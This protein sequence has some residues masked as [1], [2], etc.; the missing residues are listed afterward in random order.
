MNNTKE[1]KIEVVLS[2][3]YGKL[4]CPIDDVYK[5][6]NHITGDD[7]FTHQ[8]PRAGRFAQI[9]VLHKHPELENFYDLQKEIT[10]ENYQSYISKAI[11]M[12]GEKMKIKSYQDIWLHKDPVKEAE[13]KFGKSKIITI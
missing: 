1:F 6:C 8:L 7:L 10:P 3:I 12:Y 4:L 2:S 9:V 11:A 5:F 13:E